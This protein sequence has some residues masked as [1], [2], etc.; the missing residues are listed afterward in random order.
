LAAGRVITATATDP[1]GNT[2]EFSAAD[3]TAANG[4]VQFTISSIQLLEDLGT[5]T[6]TVQRTGGSVGTL[7]VDYSTTDGAATAGQD[8]TAQSGTL[9]FGVGET[10][11]TIQIPIIDDATTEPS[12]NFTVALRNNTSPETVG[13]PS[14]VFVTLLDSTTPPQLL[15]NNVAV[16]EGNT[17]TVEAVF[18]ISLSA[19]TGRAVSG[20]FATSNFS[21]SGGASCATQGVDY[22]SRSG[23]FSFTPGTT[24]FTIPIKVCGDTNA[25][26]NETFRMAFTNVT[27]ATLFGNVVTG[28]IGNDDILELVLEQSGPTPDQAA[29][30]DSILAVRDPFSIVGIP[31]WFSSGVDRNT[32]IVLFTRNLQLNPGELASSVFVHFIGSD[33]GIITVPA[34]DVRSVANSDLTQVTVRLPNLPVGNCIVIIQAHGTVSNQGTIR[35]AP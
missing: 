25:E 22:E 33:N 9:N 11:K 10:S 6:L 27:G 16:L 31:E 7:S 24:T 5:L 13:A 2:S 1:N 34:S 17:G 28:T 8:Y 18:T 23:T 15:I 19:A 30:L 4:S 20:N 14:T 3:P 12:E 35:I 32:R 26:A 21:A 29:A